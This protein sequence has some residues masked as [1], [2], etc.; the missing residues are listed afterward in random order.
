MSEVYGGGW[1]NT[2]GIVLVLYIL[3]VII[4]AVWV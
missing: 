4:L 3:L 1:G 2:V